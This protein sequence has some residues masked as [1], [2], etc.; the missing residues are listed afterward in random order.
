MEIYIRQLK[1]Q[2]LCCPYS[3]HSV[4]SHKRLAASLKAPSSAASVCVPW[5][6]LRLDCFQAMLSVYDLLVILLSLRLCLHCLPPVLPVFLLST[7]FSYC[8]HISL[9]KDC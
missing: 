3:K 7:Y 2:L 5:S 9:S 4:L 6:V 8:L 1:G